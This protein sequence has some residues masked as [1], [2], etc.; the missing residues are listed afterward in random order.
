LQVDA[1]ADAAAVRR[2]SRA[3][4]L[5]VHP[6]KC[7][8]THAARAFRRVMSALDVLSDDKKRR[9]YEAGLRQRGM[10]PPLR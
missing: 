8:D 10:L 6:D 2:A 1:S 5:V 9:S 3:K 4:A 7:A